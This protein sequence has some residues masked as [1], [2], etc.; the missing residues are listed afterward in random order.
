MG[1]LSFHCANMCRPPQFRGVSS[2]DSSSSP[3]RLSTFFTPLSRGFLGEP[4]LDCLFALHALSMCPH[5]LQCMPFQWALIFCNTWT[6]HLSI[7]N[8]ED[9]VGHHS[10]KNCLSV[11]ANWWT[12]GTDS[13]YILQ[14]SLSHFCLFT[15]FLNVKSL[16]VSSLCCTIS[17][18]TPHTSRSRRVSNNTIR[19]NLHW[20]KCPNMCYKVMT[21]KSLSTHTYVL[22]LVSKCSYCV[23]CRP[24]VRDYSSSRCDVLLYDW[25]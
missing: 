2:P 21:S 15:A 9:C 14:C 11:L 22:V 20:I 3:M 1:L 7:C 16:M 6:V 25:K 17:F 24:E 13:Y 18:L 23:V 4:L 10:S 5:S 8:S 19:I 12:S